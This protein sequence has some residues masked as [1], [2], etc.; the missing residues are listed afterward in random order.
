[1]S[2]DKDLYTRTDTFNKEGSSTNNSEVGPSDITFVN[3]LKALNIGTTENNGLVLPDIKSGFNLNDLAKAH[4][5]QASLTDTNTTKTDGLNFKLDFNNLRIGQPKGPSNSISLTAAK[6]SI[7]SS[8]STPPANYSIS[9]LAK[10][11]ESS[12]DKLQNQTVAIKPLKENFSR[13]W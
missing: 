12:I 11:H 7:I 10:E 2:N 3:G 9:L 5:N 1:M 4:L 6:S 8:T 13:K